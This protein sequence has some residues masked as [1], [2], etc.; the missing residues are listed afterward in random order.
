MPV[1]C[2][3]CRKRLTQQLEHESEVVL[4]RI[5]L[6]KGLHP[7]DVLNRLNPLCRLCR[8]IFQQA[9]EGETPGGDLQ[10]TKSD[11]FERIAGLLKGVRTVRTA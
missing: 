6:G 9:C 8:M 10:L 5:A 3:V 11:E 1:N 2:S 4:Q 7:A